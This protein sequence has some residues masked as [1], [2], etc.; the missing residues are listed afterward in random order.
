MIVQISAG[1]GP[2]ECQLA[3]A[4]LFAALQKE[5]D[6]LEE[7]ARTKGCEK[8]C[9]DFGRNM[10]LAALKVRYCGYAKVRSAKI[11]KGKTG[12]WM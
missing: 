9:Y 7:T 3:V 8:G 12:M 4:K 5:Y 2:A 11:I 6:D 1:Q 10:T